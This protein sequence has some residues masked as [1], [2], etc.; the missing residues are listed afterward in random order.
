MQKQTGKGEWKWA[1]GL[2]LLICSLAALI[3][4]NVSLGSPFARAVNGTNA[5]QISRVEIGNSPPQVHNVTISANDI[6]NVS[7]ISLLPGANVTVN[8]SAVVLDWNGED[9]ISV[10][11][12]TFYSSGHGFNYDSPD[13]NNYHYSAVNES[14]AVDTN[15]TWDLS[16]GD[17]YEMWAECMF[18]V[19]Y[20]SY[21]GTWSCNVTAWD[22]N[23]SMESIDDYD[24][25]EIGD[26]VALEWIT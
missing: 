13:D 17:Q 24:T 4:F 16:Y 25:T 8:C 5:T 26:L 7:M 9:D 12:A 21:N 15:C 6:F 20:Y 23:D 10:V 2:G 22:V 3:F 14:G 11:N 18:E 19:A 1:A